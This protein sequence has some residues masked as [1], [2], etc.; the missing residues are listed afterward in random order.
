MYC[1]LDFSSCCVE[2]LCNNFSKISTPTLTSTPTIPTSI[3]R[4]GPSFVDGCRSA[5]GSVLMVVGN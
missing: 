5:F 4:H 2:T 3:S 1:R